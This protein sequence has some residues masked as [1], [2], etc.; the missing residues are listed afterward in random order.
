MNGCIGLLG[1]KK[2]QTVGLEVKNFWLSI[3][4]ASKFYT[5]QI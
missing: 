5:F 4:K 3:P 2:T 1:Y